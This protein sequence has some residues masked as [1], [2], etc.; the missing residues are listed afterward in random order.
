MLILNPIQG[1]KPTADY[2]FFIVR[3]TKSAPKG[4]H[5]VPELSP[6][7]SLFFEVQKWKKQGLWPSKWED[8]RSSFVNS[9]SSG[10]L[11]EY[12]DHLEELLKDGHS[13]QLVCY[14]PDHSEC[15]KTIIGDYFFDK[16]YEV[17]YR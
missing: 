2:N 10:I 14:C 7:K 3:S 12:L 8:Y 1:C 5:H 9:M 11:A 16:G 6:P 4:F 17:D 15:H 13:V